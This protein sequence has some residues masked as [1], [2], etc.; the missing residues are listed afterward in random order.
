MGSFQ[1]DLQYA[2]RTLTRSPGYTAAALLSLGLGIGANTAIFTLTNAVF[3]HPLPSVRDPGRVLELYTVDHATASAAPL[4]ARTPVSYPNF[5]DFREQNDI[6]SGVAAFTGAGVT[7]TGFGKPAL[8]GVFLVSANYFD[9]LGV[10]A[11]AGRTFRPDEDRTPGG[12][13]VAVLSYSLWQRL[14]GGDRAAVGRT[15]NLNSVSYLVIGVAPA[16]FKGTLTV[17]PPDVVFLPLSMHAQVFAGP[18]EQFFNERRF[19]DLSL[20]G[21]LKPGVD[22]RQALASMQ[23]IAARLEAA[24]PKDN[25]GRTVETSPLS[26]AALGFIPRRQTSAGAIALSAAVGFVLLIACANIANLSLARATKRAREMGIRVA[27]GAPR[28]RLIRQLL[29]EAELL[30]LAGG[31]AGIA[32]GAF[33]AKLLWAFRPSFLEQNDVALDMDLRVLAFTLSVSLLTGMI[34]GIVPVFRA[35]VPDVASIL[36][37]TGRGNIQGGG[38][39]RLR[40]LLVVGEMAL[41]LVA[42]AGAGLF[43][44]SMQRA[45]L[46]NL[47][48]V[49]RNLCTVS[50][51]L[52]SEQ[53]TPE[54][55]RQF[56]R[57]VL[58][59]VSAVPG[60]ASA[61]IGANGPLAGGFLQTLFREG[62]PADPR[63]G[64]LTLTL[65]VTSGYFDTMRIPL[66]EG[67]GINDFDRAQ[68]RPV[69]VI[70]ESMARGVWPGQPALG[71]RFH[72]ATGTDIYEVVGIVKDTTVFNI[73]EPP[74][75]VVYLPFDQAYQPFAVVHVRTSTRPQNVLP[76]VMAAVQSLD[77]NLALLNPATIEDVIAQALWAPRFAAALFGVFGLLAMVLAVVGVYGVMAYMVLQRTSEIG[78]RMAMGADAGNVMRMVVGQSMRLAL[79]GIALGVVVA[80]GLTRLVANLL[81]DVSPN[82]PVTFGAVAVLLAG[83]ALI[84]GGIPAWRA[85]RIDPVTA[86]R[87]E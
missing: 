28:G 68:S 59:K 52:G 76:A 63:L 45:R 21:R 27:L 57:S 44:R 72:S 39:N 84:A 33:G 78:I 3:L 79:A 46:I 36:N 19:R 25:R 13:P 48:F 56:I 26:E 74:Q 51:D 61:A 22:E 7:L 42:L 53:M 58:E 32:I 43:I 75:P 38:H 80:L 69:A 34:F 30:A 23:T 81:F 60:V 8:Q 29:T 6:F 73:G 24:Y 65:P 85:A 4:N 86:L 67:R 55:G 5:V 14:F 82:D 64:M 66:I 35:S 1:Q 10:P 17:G 41:A 50:F 9:V 11:A 15:I 16:G 62:D 54:H 37:S 83:T 49:T 12:N 77:S 70:S 71:R 31:V 2:F 47:G 40:S 18:R 87:Q 20:F